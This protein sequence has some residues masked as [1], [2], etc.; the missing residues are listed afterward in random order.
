MEGVKEE[1]GDENLLVRRSEGAV[2]K[3]REIEGSLELSGLQKAGEGAWGRTEQ[4]Q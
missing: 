4:E 2:G 1:G 3:P